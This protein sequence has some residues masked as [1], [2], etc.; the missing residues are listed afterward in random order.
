[1]CRR[2]GIFK[3][4]R[5]AAL[6]LNENLV[7]RKLNAVVCEDVCRVILDKSLESAA[8][9]DQKYQHIIF[10]LETICFETIELS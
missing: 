5:A 8:V 1:M 4:Q 3:T 9:C 10:E 2:V 7:P 6:D